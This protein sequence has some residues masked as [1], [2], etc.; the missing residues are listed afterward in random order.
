MATDPALR[1]GIDVNSEGKC[2]GSL[3]PSSKL[4]YGDE[5]PGTFSSCF[6]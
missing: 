5:E 1:A 4:Y 6:A 2:D 3:V